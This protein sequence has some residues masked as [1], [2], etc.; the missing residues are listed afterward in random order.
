LEG[1]GEHVSAANVAHNGE[2]MGDKYC[3]AGVLRAP[4]ED[5]FDGKFSLGLP[6]ALDQF[7]WRLADGLSTLLSRHCCCA[8]R[9]TLKEHRSLG[10]GTDT[11]RDVRVCT[12]A[13]LSLMMT[14]PRRNKS[15]R[16]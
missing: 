10:T 8:T 5:T 15:I 1:F 4:T 6:M 14:S 16:S 11:L 3:S 12:S 7:S 2:L 13:Q 9:V